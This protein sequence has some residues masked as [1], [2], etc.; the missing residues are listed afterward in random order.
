[1][2]PE[3]LNFR[4]TESMSFWDISYQKQFQRGIV[5]LNKHS[6]I[7][8]VN[9]G[10]G[11]TN[12]LKTKICHNFCNILWHAQTSPSPE[13][14]IYLIYSCGKDLGLCWKEQFVCHLYRKRS[15]LTDNGNLVF[16]SPMGHNR[17]KSSTWFFNVIQWS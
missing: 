7:L 9:I 11:S 17:R 15:P 4:T 3:N 1:M 13:F 14:Y 6:P 16:S 2:V 5:F 10:Q 8:K 12:L